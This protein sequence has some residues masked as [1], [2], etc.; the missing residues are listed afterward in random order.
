MGIDRC[1]VGA[2]LNISA[3][4][5]GTDENAPRAEGLVVKAARDAVILNADDPLCL[6]LRDNLNGRQLILASLDE[7][8]P[9]IVRHLVGGGIVAVMQESG[10]SRDVVLKRNA[11]QIFRM[12]VN[13][14]PVALQESDVQNAIFAIA[15]AAVRLWSAIREYQAGAQRISTGYCRPL[16][17]F[18]KT[19]GLATFCARRAVRAV[20]DVAPA[21]PYCLS[22]RLGLFIGPRPDIAASIGFRHRGDG[23][24][25]KGSNRHQDR[26]KSS[27]DTPALGP[28]QSHKPD[29]LYTGFAGI[30][31]RS[32]D[33]VAFGH[34]PCLK[35]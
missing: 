12:A 1:S 8:N 32:S 25:R 21:R 7:T 31:A 10:S 35:P 27:L 33:T 30:C 11:G 29:R 22:A 15:I 4:R 18:G 20:R 28:P 26:P 16:V 34:R 2:V 9:E 19:S 24:E 14:L 5:F 17:V 13:D 23:Y 3:D 6:A